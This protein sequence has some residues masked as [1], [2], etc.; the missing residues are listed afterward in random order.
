VALQQVDA[1]WAWNYTLTN[2]K[3]VYGRF[4]GD[5]EFTKDYLQIPQGPGAL[6]RAKFPGLAPSA[7][8]TLTYEWQPHATMPGF[9]NFSSDRY[10]LAW[11]TGAPG[12]APWRLTPQPTAYGPE[13]FPGDPT[14]TTAASANRA[15]SD[16]ANRHIT[17]VLIAVKLVGQSNQLHLRAYI[18]GAPLNLRFA[19][20]ALLPVP[21]RALTV[22]FRPNR[23]CQAADFTAPRSRT[24]YFDSSRNHDAWSLTGVNPVSAPPAQ[25][26]TVPAPLASGSMTSSAAPTPSSVVQGKSAAPAS[27]IAS[28]DASAEFGSFDQPE[29]ASLERQIAGSNYTVL[30]A[31]ATVKTRGS[32]QRAFA[33]VVKANYGFKCAVTGIATREFLVASHIVP[34]ADDESIR[35]DP[36]NG[37]CLSTLVDRAFDSGFLT[38]DEKSTIHVDLVKIAGDVRLRS[39]LAPYDGAKLSIPAAC[40]PNPDY[41]R[42]RLASGGTA[43]MSK[44]P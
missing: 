1:V 27:I 22:G 25:P 32:A 15:L 40:A 37:I 44:G 4:S 31:T 19:D 5:T 10:H 13:T 12:P 26:S 38:I 34:W 18:A 42:R 43:L 24:V 2:Q 33:K 11:Q 39:V 41:L 7:P 30:D 23:A 14:A 20:A 3:A 21:V 36:R 6:L 9:V 16:F 17:G 28:D 35:L 8:L 29:V